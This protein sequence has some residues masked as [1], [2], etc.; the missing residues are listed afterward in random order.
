MKNDVAKQA[1]IRMHVASWAAE[2]AHLK[3][4]DSVRAAARAFDAAASPTKVPRP[5]TRPRA[6]TLRTPA[7]HLARSG[8]CRQRI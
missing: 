5:T 3:R 2:E 6:P 7:V 8:N 4:V 1:S